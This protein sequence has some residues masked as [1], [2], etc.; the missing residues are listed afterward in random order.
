M[1]LA[2]LEFGVAKSAK[3][4]AKRLRRHSAFAI[5]INVFAVDEAR[6]EVGINALVDTL[7][8][9][10]PF[11]IATNRHIERITSSCFD[12]L[13]DCRVGNFDQLAIENC[14]FDFGCGHG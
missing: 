9:R 4:C 13:K 2:T 3:Q 11:D 10:C 8:N 1:L 7:S 12:G 14:V 5:V 6:F